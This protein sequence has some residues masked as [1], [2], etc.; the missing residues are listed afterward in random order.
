MKALK[1][2]LIMAGGTGGHVFPGLAL[3]RHLSANGV[4]VHWLGTMNGLESRLVPA[5]NIPLHFISIQGLRGKG[6]KSL[7]SAPL[8]LLIALKQSLSVIRKIKPDIVIGMGGFASGPGGVACWLLRCPLIIHEQNAKPGFTN[9][10][11]SR[12]SRRI[13]EGFP[14]AFKQEARVMVVGNPVREEIEH[15]SPPDPSHIVNTPFRL[16]VIG[17]SLGAQ[18]LNEIVPRALLQL[19]ENLR[20]EILHQTGEKHFAAT[21]GNYESAGIKAN[22]QPFINDMAGAYSWANMVLCRAGA[23][24]IAELCTAGLGAILVPYPYATD[25]HQTANADFMVKHGAG[26]CV[27]QTELTEQKLAD[28]IRQFSASPDKRF[29]MAEAAWQLRKVDVAGKIYRILCETIN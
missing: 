6:L 3:A 17:G 12:F 1:R 23:S 24:T 18:G 29:V 2:V 7:L 11:L 14:D 25:D 28:I 26:L 16:L 20:P 10:I 22:L 27:S 21:K 13:L 19:P 4:E 8:K 9:K 15:L 5:E